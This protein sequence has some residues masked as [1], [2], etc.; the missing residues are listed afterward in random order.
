MDKENAAYKH[1][2][3]LFGFNEKGKSSIYNNMNEHRENFAK[4]HTP[5]TEGQILCDST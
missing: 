2:G 4:W 3:T 1:N 5:H